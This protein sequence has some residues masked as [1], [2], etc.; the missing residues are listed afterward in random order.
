[1]KA[2]T[3][4]GGVYPPE[5]KDMTAGRPVETLPAPGSVTIPMVQHLGASCKPMV[6]RGDIVAFGQVVGDSDAFV[7]APIHA[8]VS[9][10]V[11]SVSETRLPDGRRVPA[12]VLES[13]GEDR[14]HESIGEGAADPEALGAEEIREIVRRAGIVGMG[15]AAF[16]SHVKYTP[17]EGCEIETVILNGC[18]CEPFVTGDHR[19]ML[20]EADDVVFGLHAIVRACGARR[21]IIGVEENK[22][23]AIEA[24][25]E[26]VSG[27]PFEVV[28][29]HSKY[30]Q[31]AEKQLI[32]AVM[33]REVPAGGL[34][35]HL[36]V[37]VNN[38]STAAAVARA[39]RDGRP[40]VDRVVTVSGDVIREPKNLRVRLGTPIARLLE[41]CGGFSEDPARLVMGGPMM[42]HAVYDMDIPVVKA[43]SGVLA[44][45][46]TVAS[47]Y[48][49]GPCIRCGRCV[50]SC[51][52]FLLPLYLEAYPDDTAL[53]F[54]PL[55][56]IECGSCS[57]ICPSNRHLL[58]RI[59]LA[60]EE[61]RARQREES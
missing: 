42:G 44:L 55:D 45:S 29:L 14:P 43:T 4:R 7:S 52:S 23:D 16:P 37:I 13:D 51:P 8:T 5:F 48:E 28:V 53:D 6:N 9:G 41:A 24:L 12:V 17:P 26:A 50:R 32:T 56:C 34:P 57:Y 11:S 58:Q 38:V 35:A 19:M 20:E 49:E 36:G 25:R 18:E 59:R 54:N 27:E 60:K 40:M 47:E 30:V 33:G 46:S 39:V 3:F 22:P 2:K 1:M 21:G 61:A 10:K 15:G 31:G